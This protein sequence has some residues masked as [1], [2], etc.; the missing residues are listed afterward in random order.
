MA[1][2]PVIK[3]GFYA[4]SVGSEGEEE[5]QKEVGNVAPQWSEVNQAFIG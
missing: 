5:L 4:L 2:H 3:Q 1:D